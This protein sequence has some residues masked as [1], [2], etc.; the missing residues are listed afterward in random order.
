ML[1]HSI[2]IA[3]DTSPPRFGVALLLASAACSTGEFD[4]DY[5]KTNARPPWGE[6]FIVGAFDPNGAHL[7]HEAIKTEH[8]FVGTQWVKTSSPFFQ[9]L[10]EIAGRGHDAFVTV[11]PWPGDSEDFDVLERTLS[12]GLD[13]EY[14]L[15]LDALRRFPGRTYLRWAH[16]PEIPVDRYPWQLSNPQVYIEAFRYVSRM[17]AEL[18]PETRMVFGPTGD[19]GLR[20]FWPGSEYVDLISL[21]IYGLPAKNITD[22]YKQERFPDILQRKLRRISI[23]DKPVII[24]EFGVMG[25]P[26][27]Q[28]PWMLEA[29]QALNDCP[30]VVGAQYFNRLDVAGAWGDIPPPQW[31]VEPEIFDAFLDLLTRD[32]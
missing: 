20:R 6:P 23:Y 9:D 30:R 11:E 31:A 12:G 25:T 32:Q 5:A 21:C 16:E 17:A 4:S 24:G 10:S 1:T 7:N 28:R 18:S 22:P 19:P 29:A 26:E 27:Y 14:E 13:E 8:L 15:I 3:Q 2:Y